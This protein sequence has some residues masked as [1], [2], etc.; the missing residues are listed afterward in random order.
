MTAL[1]STSGTDQRDCALYRFWVRHP[2]TG[3]IVLGYVGETVRLPFT[4]LMEHIYDQ[5]WSDTIVRWEVDTTTYAGKQAVLA[6]E[7]AAIESERPLY[8]VEWNMGNPLRIKPWEAVAQRQAR[9][10]GWQPPV[11]GTRVPRQRR[12]A[13]AASPPTAAAGWAW[14]WTPERIKV[15]AW[16]AG[17]LLIAVVVGWQAASGPI[18]TASDGLAYGAG[19]ATIAVGLLL[20]GKRRR[21]RRFRR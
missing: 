19:V 6:A 8:N 18:A 15:A 7:K 4:R 5:P 9:E 14:E 10:P 11:R 16:A 13:T 20:P 2:T 21:R 17:W 12:T 1:P 3:R